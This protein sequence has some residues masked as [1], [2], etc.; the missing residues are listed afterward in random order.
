MN[1][2]EKNDCM[3]FLH[4]F[5]LNC[6]GFA[7][8]TNTTTTTTTSTSTTATTLWSTDPGTSGPTNLSTVWFIAS[9]WTT[10]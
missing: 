7:T 6:P 1:I 9:F 4:V 3:K 8:T 5:F 2:L 10:A